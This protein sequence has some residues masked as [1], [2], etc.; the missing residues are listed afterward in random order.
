MGKRVGIVGVGVTPFRSITPDISFKEMMFEAGAKAYDDAGISPQTDLDAFVTCEEDFEH[1]RSIFNEQTSDNVGCVLK[2][3]HTV[4]ADGIHGLIEAFM[5][6]RSGLF[7]VVAVE[8]HSKASN[9]INRN[10]LL[11]HATDPVYNKPLDF[12]P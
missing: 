8:S 6:I 4:P 7:N 10:S 1:G 2:P 5:E 3:G 9:V 11:A 12:N